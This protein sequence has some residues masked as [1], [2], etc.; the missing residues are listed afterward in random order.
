MRS[1]VLQHVLFTAALAV[2]SNSSAQQQPGTGPLRCEELASLPVSNTVIT[3]A[4]TITAGAFQPPVPDMF[5][6]PPN[7][8]GLPAFCRV[9]GSIRP[10]PESDIRFELWLPESGWNGKFL[11]TGNG[12]AAGA[13]VYASLVEPLRRGYAVANTDTGHQGGGAD[14][15]WAAGQLQKLIDYQYRAVHELT[16]AGKALTAARYARAPEKSYWNGCSTGG[17]QGLMEAQR[18]PQDYD[19]IIAGAPA[20]NWH[21]LMALSL[22]IQN[23]LGPGRLGVDQLAVLKE[24][25]IAAC[26]ARDGVTDRVITDPEKCDFD[27]ASL[28]CRGS[29]NGPCL[30]PDEIAAAMRIYAGVVDRNGQVLMPGTGPGGEPQWAWFQPG[31]FDIGANYFRHVVVN[32]P[33][34]DPATF[35]AD[36]DLAPADRV[37]G[38]ATAAM[39]PDLA[40]FIARGGKLITWHGTTDGLIPY[41]N[42][43]NYHQSV[44]SRLGER[45]VGDAVKFYLIPGMD[46]CWGGEGAFEVDWLTVLEDWVERGEKPGA[47]AAAHPE[48]LYGPPG[49]PPIPSQ[50]FTRLICPWPQ[51]STYR[52]GDLA[53]AA[54][55]ACVAP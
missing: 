15:S 1:A 42:S 28:E 48:L 53:A 23:N 55:F 54:S 40:A 38:G 31:V 19:G 29:E 27:P 6:P 14:F 30:A 39:D 21:P 13:I 51:M 4:G 32:D 49:T 34:W 47:V 36:T 5:G 18:F 12:G 26:D 25:A 22:L 41:R 33:G 3:S 2:G 20:S 45:E 44:L 11:Q 17:R 9:A 24:A 7:Y 43:V 37:D 10:S 52:E 16:V 46:H 8:A 50:P 35:D